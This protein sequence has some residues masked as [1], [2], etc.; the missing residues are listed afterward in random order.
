MNGLCD[1]G[2]GGGVLGETSKGVLEVGD[3]LREGGEGCE[4]GMG[5]YL[6][7]VFKEL[8]K[9][10]DLPDLF[11]WFPGKPPVVGG[12]RRGAGA[13]EGLLRHV[14]VLH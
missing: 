5:H 6:P 4:R 9:L 1:L 14:E 12:R 10:I 8:D 3:I 11:G 13:D 7:V 2:V